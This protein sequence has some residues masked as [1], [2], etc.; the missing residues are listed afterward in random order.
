M[1]LQSIVDYLIDHGV[2]ENEVDHLIKQKLFEKKSIMD[3]VIKSQFEKAMKAAECWVLGI[4]F[5]Y[6]YE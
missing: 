5:T 1:T 4:E 6:E 2:D 3:F